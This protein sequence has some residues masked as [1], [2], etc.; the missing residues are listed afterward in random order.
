MK[1]S[2][3]YSSTLIQS[4]VPNLTVQCGIS[5]SPAA[6]KQSFHWKSRARDHIITPGSD[7]P[8]HHLAIVQ[9]LSHCSI[10]QWYNDQSKSEPHVHRLTQ[11]VHI[12]HLE[13]E[14]K[15][16]KGL[17]CCLS[18]SSC[19]WS[20]LRAHWASK[21]AFGGKTTHANSCESNINSII[22]NERLK[23]IVKRRKLLTFLLS[24]FN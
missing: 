10:A 20:L 6:I 23:S 19:R 13:R 5:Q 7:K 8:L 18:D 3:L 2:P 21:E 17:D 14:N 1:I 11:N 22:W 15:D 9:R 12:R 4:Q 24:I 16:Q